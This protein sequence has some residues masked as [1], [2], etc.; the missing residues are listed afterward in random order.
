LFAVVVWE[1]AAAGNFYLL[2]V[3]VLAAEDGTDVVKQTEVEQSCV[4]IP[5]EGIPAPLQAV[6]LVK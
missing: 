4:V 2:V 5:G 6:E 3:A 1:T